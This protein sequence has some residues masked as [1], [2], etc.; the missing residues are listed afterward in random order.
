MALLQSTQI[1]YQALNEYLL[2]QVSTFQWLSEVGDNALLWT[3]KD[4]IALYPMIIYKDGEI[5]HCCF[6]IS[7]FLDVVGDEA[8]YLVL[9]RTF[10]M[11][12]L[13]ER[14]N[15]NIYKEYLL[16]YKTECLVS[17]SSEP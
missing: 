14:W 1:T 12:G 13:A 5:F 7:S 2:N 11:N 3:L 16:L 4:L 17:A 15:E 8:A 10:E 9:I 6:W